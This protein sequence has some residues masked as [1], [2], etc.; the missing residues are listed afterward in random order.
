MEEGC[1]VRS[2]E[3]ERERSIPPNK[4]LGA[5]A[6]RPLLLMFLLT[7]ALVMTSSHSEG[8]RVNETRRFITLV[9][10]FY[11][12]HVKLIATAQDR[13]VRRNPLS[14]QESARGH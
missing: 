14:N 6:C 1:F 4:P 8:T 11:E 7:C 5:A 10:T 13:P 3:E 12:H 2:E 9:D